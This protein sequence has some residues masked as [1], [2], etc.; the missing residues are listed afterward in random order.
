LKR[1]LSLLACSAAA[2]GAAAPACAQVREVPLARAA[3]ELGYS[4]SYIG[5]SN[6][7][8]VSR[9]GL[10]IL[11]RPGQQL[12]EVNDA[13]VSLEAAP[14]ELD[15]TIYVPASLV[16]EMRRLARQYP[17][18]AANGGER[19]IVVVTQPTARGAV[20]LDVR[21]LL[22]SFSLAISGKAPPSVP[23]TLTLIGTFSKEIPDVL[24]SRSE[25]ASDVDGRF[26]AV[27]SVAPG[28][29]EGGLLTLVAT[30]LPGVTRASAQVVM[31]NPNWK[32][33][34]PGDEVPKS[35]DGIYG[36]A[37]FPQ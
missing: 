9:P 26:Q 36:V 8:I 12:A 30:S 33:T 29:F 27:V 20:S 5:Y 18:A 24:L 37:T 1:V 21:Q 17:A 28:F 23:I 25:V 32:V 34:V 19:S 3:S 11:I 4:Y 22:G 7:A 31:K 14:I 35:V 10:T 13:L 6:S 15:N 2:F 16:A